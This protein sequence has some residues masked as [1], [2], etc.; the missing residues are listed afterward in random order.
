[1]KHWFAPDTIH[2]I[3]Q[4]RKLYRVMKQCPTD[5]VVAKYKCLS[6]IVRFKTRQDTRN[7]VCTLSGSPSKQFW[8]WV[9]SV[10][11]HRAPLPP[12]LHNEPV[13]D[14]YAKAE[15]FNH[16][17]N[18]VFTNE[19]MADF[20]M[21][22][23]S[24]VNLSPILETVSFSPDVVYQ[25]LLHLNV[26]KACGPDLL[27]PL[28]LKKAAEF[29]CLPLSNLFN[30][31]MS[32]GHLPR[33]WV[34]ANVIPVHKK[35]NK[36]LASN[37]RPIS[38][39]SVIVKVMERIIHR[40]MIDALSQSNRLSVHQFGFRPNHS[41]VSLLLNAVNDWALNL[42]HRRT[43]HCLFLD[44]AKAFDT[45][46]HERLLLK[47]EA[48]GFTGKL[49]NWFRG[50]LTTCSQR[51]VVNGSHSS[52]LTVRFGVPQGSVLGPLFFL[53]YV[54]DIHD[55][56]FHSR[57]KLFADDVAIYK[58][59]SASDDCIQLQEDLNCIS[60]WA[61][62]WQ[63]KLNASKCEALLISRKRSPPTFDYNLKGISLS[64]KPLVHYLGI[65]I[66]CKLGWSD[67]C[68]IIAAKATRC[69]NFLRH[70]MWSAPRS[71]KSLAYKV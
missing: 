9:N 50:F 13:T 71:A 70:T 10:K 35:G 63:L 65:Y 6:N 45:V 62:R 24:L 22:N 48:I 59:I 12:L 19:N 3:H 5:L 44:F 15:V 25:E 38:L 34:T 31:S 64:W 7:K 52:W 14:D 30:Q 26:S 29:I 37:Y 61:D 56:V 57:I 8:S 21:V 53:I 2:L 49:L 28:I 55:V 47:L 17:F 60:S 66:N 18:S 36:R 23:S 41:T 42:E 40:H 43:S 51:V 32:S 39:S 27:P 4:K 58:A 11:G 1:M 33:D 54:N 20:N 68:K 67:H 16:Y 46:P 69:L